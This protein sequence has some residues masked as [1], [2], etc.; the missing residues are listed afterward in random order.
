[1]DYDPHANAY[2]VLSEETGKR[3]SKILGIDATREPR[4]LACHVTP[5]SASLRPE[6][7]ETPDEWTF[8][9]GCESCHGSAREWLNEHWK[10]DWKTK[11][12]EAK[13]VYGMNNL[14]T[15]TGRARVCVGC[16]VGAPAG[17]GLPLRDMNHDFIA[18]GHPRLMFEFG[19]F[20]AN[21]PPH[22]NTKKKSRPESRPDFEARAWLIGQVVSAQAAL[23]LLADRARAQQKKEKDRP[24][25]EFS[26][27]DCYAC[28]N[29]IER[30][31]WRV[32]RAEGRKQKGLVETLGRPTLS[33]WYPGLL[34][35]VEEFAGAKKP[36]SLAALRKD[37]LLFYPPP[38]AVEK[39]ARKAAEGLNDL[40][41]KL[42][43]KEPFPPAR[44]A[45]L[46]KSLAR[47]GA[48]ACDPE[49]AG[50]LKD[51][52]VVEQLALGILALVKAENN[53]ALEVKAKELLKKL[54]FPLGPPAF[55]SPRYFHRIERDEKGEKKR[56][57]DA[58][59]KTLFED[60]AK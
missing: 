15:L 59:L 50:Q 53:K 28:H 4:C 55:D 60:L 29:G 24:W 2:R 56:V 16:H 47:R 52:D 7:G 22:W 23:R 40:L 27:Y 36:D 48:E 57:A 14:F 18:A 25:P 31:S 46:R 12:V 5:Q 20:L 30:D 43:P 26:E 51:W 32:N 17:D 8:G 21:L 10:E 3:M 37:M 9:V 6:R 44:L 1:M 34:G 58:E 35:E 54:A 45:E 41:P 33:R 11:T 13:Q 19:A 49:K 42:D 39:Q 38:G